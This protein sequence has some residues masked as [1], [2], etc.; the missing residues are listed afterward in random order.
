MEHKFLSIFRLWRSKRYRK[1]RKKWLSFIDFAF[2]NLLIE[3]NSCS[4]TGVLTPS[5][6]RT[7]WGLQFAWHQGSTW[8]GKW[9][10]GNH[11]IRFL[12]KY[13]KQFIK[14]KK[15]LTE[16]QYLINMVP[17]FSHEF[18]DIIQACSAFI[19]CIFLQVTSVIIYQFD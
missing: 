10:W 6:W 7:S 18:C 17:K 15:K 9:N 19:F 12:E 3:E 8:F 5:K 13:F 11:K 2:V 4:Q 1:N 14:S 16:I